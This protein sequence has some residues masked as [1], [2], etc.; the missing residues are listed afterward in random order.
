MSK[1]TTTILIDYQVTNDPA[2]FGDATLNDSLSYRS[3]GTGFKTKDVSSVVGGFNYVRFVFRS[4]ALAYALGVTTPTY[5]AS[6][7][8]K[9]N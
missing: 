7:T 6:I 2:V 3:T 1:D 4:S 9:G 5:T 8:L